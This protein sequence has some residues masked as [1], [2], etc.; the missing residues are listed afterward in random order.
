MKLLLR[1]RSTPTS[2]TVIAVPTA[3]MT[4]SC[5]PPGKLDGAAAQTAAEAAHGGQNGAHLSIFLDE[6]ALPRSFQRAAHFSRRFH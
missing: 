3:M 1:P 5:G 2:A 6:T 4:C